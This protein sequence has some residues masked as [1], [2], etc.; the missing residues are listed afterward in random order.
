MSHDADDFA[1]KF[2]GAFELFAVTPEIV[3]RKDEVRTVMQ[4]AAEML[5]G[6]RPE[7]DLHTRSPGSTRTAR[8]DS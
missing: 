3:K 5:A 1:G 4:I 8:C 7:A 2:E 6:A